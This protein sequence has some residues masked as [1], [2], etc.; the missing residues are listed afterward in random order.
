MYS[1]DIILS[2]DSS[3]YLIVGDF[4]CFHGSTLTIEAGVEIA[5]DLKDRESRRRNI[6]MEGNIV[7]LGQP[8]RPIMF[9]PVSDE[10]NRQPGD[11]GSVFLEGSGQVSIFKYCNFLCPSTAIRATGHRVTLENCS[12]DRADSSDGPEGYGIWACDVD[13]LVIAQCTFSNNR[14]GLMASRSVVLVDGSDFIRNTEFGIRLDT[15]AIRMSQCRLLQNASG[16]TGV[17]LMVLNG[18]GT[19]TSC[20]FSGSLYGIRLFWLSDELMVTESNLFDNL[21]GGYNVLVDTASTVCDMTHNFWGYSSDSLAAITATISD[22][23]IIRFLPVSD[24]P[25][26]IGTILPPF[27]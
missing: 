10:S 6:T 13:S 15:S 3:P 23:S 11:W 16:S 12:F 7:A 25:Y 20:E 2:L 5:F 19:V 17:G 1:Q 18:Y 27:K 4:G 24:T 9:V 8:Q 14:G 21:P 22:T 26:T